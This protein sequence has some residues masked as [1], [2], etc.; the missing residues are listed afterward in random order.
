MFCSWCSTWASRRRRS[1]FSASKSAIRCSREATR[2][3]MAAWASGGTVFQSGAGI[4]GGGTIPSTTKLLYRKFDLGMA[5]AAPKSRVARGERLNSYPKLASLWIEGNEN[6]D[7]LSKEDKE[8]F[9]RIWIVY[10]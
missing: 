8:R 2:A 1:A 4:E 9:K 6:Y 7:S 5:R 10:L 3:R